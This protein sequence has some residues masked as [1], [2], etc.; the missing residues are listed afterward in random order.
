MPSASL[1][2]ALAGKVQA[3]IDALSRSDA[4]Y[5]P[6]SLTQRGVL[7]IV[8]RGID[9]VAPLLHEFTYQAFVADLLDVHSRYSP[10]EGGAEVILDESDPVWVRSLACSLC[11]RI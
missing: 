6:S 5:P 4:S 7:L 9:V 1:A 8:D 2:E 11:A 3:S 10:D